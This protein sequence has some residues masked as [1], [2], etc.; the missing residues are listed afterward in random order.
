[1]PFLENKII[2]FFKTTKT[3]GIS[4]TTGK[5]EKWKTF[6]LFPSRWIFLA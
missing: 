4:G 6:L 5:S 3:K 2:E 1:M